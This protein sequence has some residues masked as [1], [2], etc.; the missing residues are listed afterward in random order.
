MTIKNIKKMLQENKAQIS[1][2]MIILLAAIIAIVLVV[3]TQLQST[4][5]KANTTVTKESDKVF[6]KIDDID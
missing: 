5:K 6:D 1:A 2:E 4:T 3:V